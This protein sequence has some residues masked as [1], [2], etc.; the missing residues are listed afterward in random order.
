MCSVL[1]LLGSFLSACCLTFSFQSLACVV[2]HLV[3]EFR[4]FGEH[5]DD[6]FK[7]EFSEFC[8][9]HGITTFLGG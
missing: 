6:D 3:V 9:C 7:P 5:G 1:Y 8:F 2:F 4:V